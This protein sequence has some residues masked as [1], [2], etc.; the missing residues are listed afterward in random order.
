MTDVK[1]GG[2]GL[3]VGGWVGDWELGVGSGIGVGIFDCGLGGESSKTIQIHI[4]IQFK[5]PEGTSEHQGDHPT[6]SI[7]LNSQIQS[8]LSLGL[9]IQSQSK[10]P[11]QSLTPNP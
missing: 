10:F 5:I 4:P 11:T 8:P 7:N 3:G 2:W 9:N 6:R 1:G